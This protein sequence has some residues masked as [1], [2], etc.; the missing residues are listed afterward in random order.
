M[1]LR[2]PRFKPSRRVKSGGSATVAATVRGVV[3]EVLAIAREMLRI[4][5]G[6]YMTVAEVAGAWTLTAWRFALPVM[7][8]LWRQA[9][10]LF[11]VAER[12]V[13]P[14]R[15][16]LAVAGVTALALALS[17]FADYRTIAIG[18]T[19]YVGVDQIAPAPEAAGARAT[20]GSAHAW[21]GLPLAIAAL[22]AV[23]ACA[24]GNGRAAW[25]LAPIG[26]A[27]VAISLIVDA[28]KGLDEGSAA[29]AY[30]GAEAS[31][32]GGFWVQLACG[33][34]LV[35]LAPLIAGLLR[36][37]EGTGAH[38]RWRRRLPFGRM[39]AGEAGG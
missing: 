27:T 21:L 7:Q 17:Q 39:P 33:V 8:V 13:T 4:P 32:L 25:W 5:A 30:E 11:R 29:I 12:E 20:A 16:A 22:V 34:L 2:E 38:A 18:T 23:A 10:R 19:D 14:V 26:L 35:A 28:P 31:L 37:D 3:A 24:R 36:G 1:R 15:A 6:I 9:V